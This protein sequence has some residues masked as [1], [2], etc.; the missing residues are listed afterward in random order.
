MSKYPND[1]YLKAIRDEDDEK[2]RSIIDE[3]LPV[4]ERFLRSN[5]GTKE[6]AEDILMDALTVI[7]INV[8]KSDF[9]LTSS[10]STYLFSIC[11]NHWLNTLRKKKSERR[12]I[13]DVE[14]VFISDDEAGELMIQV[15]LDRLFQDNFSKLPVDC[16]KILA[17]SFHSDLNM[18]EIA[19]IQGW[20]Y[21]YACKRKC[22]CIQKLTRWIK[23]DGRCTD[24]FAM[25][26]SG[27][28]AEGEKN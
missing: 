15:E 3:F 21:N 7:W 9:T 23:A 22:N 16:Q 6:D 20:T 8:S 1:W 28:K 13:T 4:I 19:E 27:K 18:K 10:F 11:R 26:R 5:H 24:L 25:F 12:V 2:I 14:R 17:L